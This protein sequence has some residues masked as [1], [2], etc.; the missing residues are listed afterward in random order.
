ML[1]LVIGLLLFGLLTLQEGMR[2]SAISGS[3]TLTYPY[4]L[5]ASMSPEQSAFAACAA[6]VQ[7]FLK[8]PSSAQYPAFERRFVANRG[9]GQYQVNAYV[10]TR[11]SL[12]IVMRV[13]YWCEAKCGEDGRCVIDEWSLADR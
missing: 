1:A 9:T 4:T 3:I 13:D 8:A 2:G 7:P 11:N 12:G 10:D 6:L 5:A